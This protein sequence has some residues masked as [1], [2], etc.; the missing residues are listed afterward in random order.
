M[1]WSFFDLLCSRFLIFVGGHFWFFFAGFNLS[2]GC[3]GPTLSKIAPNGQIWDFTGS[4][5]DQSSPNYVA[6]LFYFKKIKKKWQ[7]GPKKHKNVDFREKKS[8][9]NT[10]FGINSSSN[11]IHSKSINL[12]IHNQILLKSIENHINI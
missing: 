6:C 9:P 4:R 12:I 8:W 2:V 10:K 5:M 7:H 3:F 11:I 1:F